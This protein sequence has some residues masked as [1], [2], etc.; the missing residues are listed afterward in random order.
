MMSH[1]RE[2]LERERE[3]ERKREMK[4]RRTRL[5]EKVFVIKGAM[6]FPVGLFVSGCAAALHH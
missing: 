1:R 4:R 2:E 6:L 5:L 3:R